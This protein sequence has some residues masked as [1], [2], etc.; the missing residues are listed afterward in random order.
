LDEQKL[1]HEEFEDI[2][3]MD[4]A[5]SSRNLYSFQ[6]DWFF[7]RPT[8]SI[9][10]HAGERG[11]EKAFQFNFGKYSREGTK[12]DFSRGADGNASAMWEEWFSK[13]PYAIS[14]IRHNNNYILVKLLWKDPYRDANIIYNKSNNTCQF[15]LDFEEKV[16]FDPDIVTDEYVMRC[17]RWVDLKKCITSDMLDDTQKKIFEELI[18]SEDETNPI[19]IKYWFK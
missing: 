7:F 18:Q 9:V 1:L 12:A 19:L 3:Q 14:T 11:L 5:Y 15:I 16:E 4:Y 17:C 10:Y 6:N 2:G 13:Y 8:S